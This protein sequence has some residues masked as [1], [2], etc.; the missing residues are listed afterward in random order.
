VDSYVTQLQ[1]RLGP[2]F[3]YFI[4]LAILAWWPLDDWLYGVGSHTW[5]RFFEFRAGVSAFFLSFGTL[6]DW[7]KV[8]VR[9]PFFTIAAMLSAGWCF[10]GFELG[11][12]AQG[13][14]NWFSYLYLA[15]LFTVFVPAS[16]GRRVVLTFS[17][18]AGALGGFWLGS[19][20]SLVNLEWFSMASFFSFCGVLAVVMGQA[21]FSLVLSNYEGQLRLAAQEQQL[22][23]LTLTLQERVDEQTLELRRLMAHLESSR[24]E[25]RRWMARELHDELGQEFAALR[26]A[27]AYGRRA[28]APQAMSAALAD[29]ESL[30]DQTHATLRRLLAALRPKV[31]DE[32]GLPGALR[33]LGAQSHERF[34]LPVEVSADEVPSLPTELATALFR[35]TQEAL[36]NVARHAGATRAWVE[37]VRDD[38]ALELRVLDDGRGLQAD[39]VPGFG[40]VGI[41]ER[42]AAHGGTVNWRSVAAIGDAPGGC[43]M[44]ARVPLEEVGAP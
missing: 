43:A 12:I 33:W 5:D 14:A 20:P 37:L 35:V 4:L 6:A 15:P 26:L 30:L 19:P 28:P 13:N 24:E 22:R 3:A 21:V 18:S 25:E 31:L 23:Q 27:V 10:G 44:I 11:R 9:A 40:M 1:I 39:V 17:I 2:R 7:S 36:T 32:L 42:L 34:E 29:V 38:G 16:L 8:F 41:R